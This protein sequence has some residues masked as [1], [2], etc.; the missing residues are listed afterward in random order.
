MSDVCAFDKLGAHVHLTNGA[1]YMPD[2][3]LV[4]ALSYR[5]NTMLIYAPFATC[6]NQTAAL[7]ASVIWQYSNMN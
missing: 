2:K 5:I 1:I 6:A 7:E 3:Q 4:I